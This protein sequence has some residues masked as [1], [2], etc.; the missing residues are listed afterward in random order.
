M[1]LGTVAGSSSF[2]FFFTDATQSVHLS[3]HWFLISGVKLDLI[4]LLIYAVI[5]DNHLSL[6]IAACFVQLI[7]A[8]IAFC[9]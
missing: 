4:S 2:L 5:L 1:I 8:E 9:V 6:F 3:R 7:K